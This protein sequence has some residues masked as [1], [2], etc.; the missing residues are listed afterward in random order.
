[1]TPYCPALLDRFV[2]LAL[3]TFVLFTTLPTQAEIIFFDDFETDQGWMVNPQGNDSAVSGYWERGIPTETDYQLSSAY[4]GSYMLVTGANA[5]S[6]RSDDVDG[7][8]TSIQSPLIPLPEISSGDQISLNLQKYA[9]FSQNFSTSYFRIL[10]QGA[11]TELVYE[12]SGASATP[13]VWAPLDIDISQFSGQTISISIR[14]ADYNGEIVEAGVDDVSI[15]YTRS[16]LSIGYIFYDDFEADKDWITNPYG[17]DTSSDGY[18]ERGNPGATEYQLEEAH[19]GTYQLVTGADGGSS[20]SDNLEGFSSIRSPS[21]SIPERYLG[22]RLSLNLWYYFSHNSNPSEDGFLRITLV[23]ESESRVLFT[24]FSN[25]GIT[26]PAWQEL[27]TDI[28]EFSAQTVYLL[29]EANEGTGTRVEV[30]IDDVS[31]THTP[32]PTSS[33]YL[34]RDFF[35]TDKGWVVNPNGSDTSSDGFW[36]RGDPGETDYQLDNAHSGSFQLITGAD[37]GS[38][39]S[40]DL[41]NF[42][43]VRSPILPLPALEHGASLSLDL[44]YYLSHDPNMG[45]DGFLRI[46]V[47]GE[48]FSR[49]LLQKNTNATTVFPQW[50][51]LEADISDFSGETIYLLVE[52]REGDSSKIEAGIDDLRHL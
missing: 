18:W 23:G 25:S 4:S 51:K 24:Q 9:V 13:Y 21:I 31:I 36:E 47:V 17:T 6:N 12:I 30:G 11:T 29:I 27:E 52:A 48:S 50:H 2:R 14:V 43:S 37:G 34:F 19:S 35:E 22:E 5:T 1:M 41:E 40:D 28:S 20:G 8:V 10:I 15:I 39:G 26:Y 42:S 44:W 45:D 46:S 49:V 33:T 32:A 38:N 3:L 16:E 7:G